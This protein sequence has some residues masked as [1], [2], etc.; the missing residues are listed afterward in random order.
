M[1]SLMQYSG[2]GQLIIHTPFEQ[3]AHGHREE[4]L[5][6]QVGIGFHRVSY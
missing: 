5:Q 2:I 3:V 6:E 4:F 1:L